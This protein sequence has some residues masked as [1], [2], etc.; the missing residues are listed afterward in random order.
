MSTHSFI[1][2]PLYLVGHSAGARAALHALCRPDMRS[3]LPRSFTEPSLSGML[4][5]DSSRL[6]IQS[7]VEQGLVAFAVPP[8]HAAHKRSD[9][10]RLGARSPE[11]T[12]RDLELVGA[13]ASLFYFILFILSSR[14]RARRRQ[15]SASFHP[16][17]ARSSSPARAAGRSRRPR[18]SS[19]PSLQVLPPPASPSSKSTERTAASS[20]PRGRRRPAS[21]P[22]APRS[23][24][25]SREGRGG[26]R[27]GAAGR[28]GGRRRGEAAFGREA[29]WSSAG[30]RRRRS[31][32]GH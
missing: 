27:R 19:A 17:T 6:L 12:S 16:A 18:R 9:E 15:S 4:K 20:S 11:V 21:A 5:V 23:T 7:S 25:S 30:W 3:Q 24:R 28:R 14:E 29:A 1:R 22:L 26:G 31:T 13:K 10:S 32:G 8:A 2:R